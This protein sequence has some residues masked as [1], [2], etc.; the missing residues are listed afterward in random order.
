MKAQAATKGK[1]AAPI[2]L[3]NISYAWV[4]CRLVL[5]CGRIPLPVVHV[6]DKHEHFPTEHGKHDSALNSPSKKIKRIWSILDT[7]AG[8]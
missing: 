3:E 8:R 4:K 6:E 7:E 5:P 2:F 1:S